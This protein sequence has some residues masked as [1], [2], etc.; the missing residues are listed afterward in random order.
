MKTTEKK[1]ISE[2]R[3]LLSE[4]ERLDEKIVLAESCTGGKVSASITSIPGASDFFCGSHVVYRLDSKMDWLK[5]SPPLLSRYTAV[6]PIV[7]EKLALAALNKTPEADYAASITG[8]LGPE[9]DH[10]KNGLIYMGFAIR[11]NPQKVWHFKIK[12]D[13]HAPSTANIKGRESFRYHMQLEASH[14]LLLMVRSLL[15]ERS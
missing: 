15:S 4:L 6:H 10:K 9:K 2:A 3:K 7:A 12:I 13:S 1:L 11:A 14:A 5:I 8:Y